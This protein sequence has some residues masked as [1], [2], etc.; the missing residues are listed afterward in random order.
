MYNVLEHVYKICLENFPQTVTGKIKK[1]ELRQQALEDFP[2]LR[3]EL[4]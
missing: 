3:N 2:E 1:F 4:E